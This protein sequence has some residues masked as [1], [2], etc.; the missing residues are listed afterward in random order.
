MTYETIRWERLEEVVR[1]SHDRP[2][3]RN[4]ESAQLLAE[5][6]HAFAAAEADPDIRVVILAGVGDHFSAG[7][8]LKEAEQTRSDLTTEQ[9]WAFELQLYYGQAL[10][11]FDLR[12]PTIAQVQGACIAGAFMLAN[13]CDLVVASEDAFFSDPVTHSLGA[14][15]VEVLIHPWVMGVR[16][17][18]EMLYTGEPMTAGE[19]HRIGLVNRVVAR[20]ELEAETLALAQRIA[21]APPFALEL[22]KRSLN[23]TLEMQGLKVALQA[24][25]DTHQLS[26][27]AGGFRAARDAGLG[28]AILSR[29]E[30]HRQ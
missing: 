27:T 3:Q 21:K 16:K 2:R 12:K 23:R 1:L 5:L 28:R 22:V 17:S 20:P 14:A 30:T 10:R 11:L 15:S 8:D 13:M 24:H 29:P 25:F 26:H 7:H 6:D 19:A 4:A 18:K 9:R